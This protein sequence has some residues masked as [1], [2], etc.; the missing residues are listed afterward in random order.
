MN[1][2]NWSYFYFIKI[3]KVVISLIIDL[4]ISRA[5]LIKKRLLLVLSI[6]FIV[7]NN[8]PWKILSC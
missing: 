2:V 8:A 1:L 5:V 4:A 3:V 7:N 6:V